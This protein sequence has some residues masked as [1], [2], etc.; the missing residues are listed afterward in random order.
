MFTLAALQ[1]LVLV[2]FRHFRAEEAL[3]NLDHAADFVLVN[4]CMAMNQYLTGSWLPCI[5][6]LAFRLCR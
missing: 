3:V 1:R 2:S 4:R 6:V 5:T